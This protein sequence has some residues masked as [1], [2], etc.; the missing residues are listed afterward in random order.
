MVIL[1]TENSE[2]LPENIAGHSA[3]GCGIGGP[4]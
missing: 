4:V 2:L 1:D 3:A